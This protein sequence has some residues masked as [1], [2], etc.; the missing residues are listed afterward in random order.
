MIYAGI[1]IAKGEHVIGAIDERGA[2]AAKPM[3]F[4]NSTSGFERCSAYLEGLGEPKERVLVG[5]EATGHYWLPLFCHL[6]GEGYEVVVINPMRTDAMRRF[7]GSSRVKTDLIDCV[8]IAETLRL[9]E[10]EPSRLGDEAMI[11]LRQLTRLHQSLKESVAD[12]KRQVIVALDQVF[13]EYDSIFSD[14]FGESSRALLKRC[15]TPEECLRIRVDSIAKTLSAASHG[16]LG[17]AKADEI[18]AVAKGSCG[19]DV[20]TQAFSFQIKLLVE[21]IDFIEGQARDVERKI[22]EGIEAI[23]PLIL[24][25]PGIGHVLGA[26][27]V[28]EIGDIRRFRNASAIVSYAGINPS[29]SQS[30]K[31]SS[32][33]NHITKQGS[34]YLRRALYLAATAQIRLSTPLRDYYDKKR[35]DGKSHREALIAV[36]RKLT[37]VI[38][39]VLSKQ[40]PYRPDAVGENQA[41]S[42]SE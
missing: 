34:P 33:E 25:I 16:K 9:G 5:M 42:R 40:E 3:S 26:Q 2:N 13:P 18:K 31:F 24:T 41:A 4:S 15:A 28:S 12:L 10:F 39:A 6:Q 1:D 19:I 7:K 22:K 14:T 38:Y 21:Q 35:M 29:I 37:H 11:E 32:G 23:E 8:L 27:I 20:A 30:G 17:R 36:A